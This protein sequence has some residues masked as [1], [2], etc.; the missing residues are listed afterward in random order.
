MFATLLFVP[1]VQALQARTT[2]RT[3]ARREE[4]QRRQDILLKRRK[5]SREQRN[6]E[7]AEALHL[8]ESDQAVAA[9]PACEA[10]RSANGSSELPVHVFI[11]ALPA[12]NEI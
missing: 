5:E 7:E 3:T 11:A 4:E 9:S 1:Y 6:R 8:I 10:A 12:N 2:A